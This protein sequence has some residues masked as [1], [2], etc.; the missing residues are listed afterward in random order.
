MAPG[1]T[2]EAAFSAHAR[3]RQC[4]LSIEFVRMSRPT[5]GRLW[6]GADLDCRLHLY[7]A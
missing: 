2:Q 5:Y 7:H 1:R 3:V 6:E 4:G